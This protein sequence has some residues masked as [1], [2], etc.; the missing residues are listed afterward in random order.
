MLIRFALILAGASAIFAQAPVRTPYPVAPDAVNARYGPHERNVLDV[1]KGKSPGSPLVVFIHG[2]GFTGGDKKQLPQLLLQEARQAGWAVATINYRFSTQAP[3]P[4]PMADSARAVQFLRL[5]AMEWNINPKAIAATGSSAGSGISLWMG[6]HDDM[7]EPS[8]GDPVM[9]QSTRLSAMGVMGAQTAY[10][11]RFVAALVGEE[12]G[13]H[14]ALATL[15]GVPRGADVFTATSFFK[16]YEDGSAIT[17]L[18]AG[19][20]PVFMYYSVA[21]YPLPV[22]NLGDG[23]HNPRFGYAL[24]ERM[25]K[26]GIECIVR[27]PT[28]YPAGPGAQALMF[29]DMIAFFQKYFPK[30]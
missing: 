10:D 18:S 5:H 24:K 20:P 29:R 28:D 8:S 22:A 23:I 3:Y 2:G 25:D 16:L 6:Y 12:I 26:L 30:E 7:A 9:R 21:M 15:F 11:P 13:R 17:H 4:A 14:P 19:D 27:A 1:W